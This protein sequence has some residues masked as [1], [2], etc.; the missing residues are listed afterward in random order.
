[1]IMISN[2]SERSIIHSLGANKHFNYDDI[3][4]EFIKGKKILLIAGTFL[5]PSFDGD[6]AVKLLRFA[7]ENGVLCCMDTAWDSTGEWMH[8][9]E[10]TLQYLDWF[11]PS[12]DEAIE[13]SNKTDPEEIALF[14]QSKGAKNVIIKLN[15]EGCFVKQENARGFLVPSYGGIEPVDASGAGDS[16]CAG[17]IAGLY[18]GWDIA[19][20]AKF[21]NAIGAHCIMHI[22]TT[23]GIKPMQEV[24]DFM[25]IY[26]QSNIKSSA[27]S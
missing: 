10:D 20:C 22:G 3:D 16:F 1:M 13:L 2:D 19:K 26:E 25:N 7:S 11:M 24:L 21:G 6:G 9:I 8:K 18:S 4:L 17:F 15:S 5:M 27:I 23:T 12:Y 14:F